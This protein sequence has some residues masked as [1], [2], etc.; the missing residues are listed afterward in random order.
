MDVE[1]YSNLLRRQ[2]N[3]CPVGKA[4]ETGTFAG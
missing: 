4:T 2:R 3:C 1:E